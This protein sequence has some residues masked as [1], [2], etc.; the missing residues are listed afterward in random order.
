[1]GKLDAVSG[2][3]G[4][5]LRIAGGWVRDRLLGRESSDMDIAVTGGDG[6]RVARAAARMFGGD[7]HELGLDKT[8]S[9]S[10]RV[11]GTAIDGMD[12]EFVPMRTEGY[13]GASRVPT[14]LPTDSVDE[15][16][17]RRDFT[18]NA[19]Y[20]NTHTSQVEDPTGSGLSDLRAGVLRTPDDPDKSMDDD[21]L[22]GF[23]AARFVSQLGFRAD[24]ALVA[25][26]SRPS[27]H[28]RIESTVA[29]ERYAKELSKLATSDNPAA[30]AALLFDTGMYRAMLGLNA[31]A[32]WSPITM[33][34]R[35][36]YHTQNLRDHV[37]SV[38]EHAGKLATE[39]GLDR[40][41]RSALV[42]AAMFH[43]FGKMS[44]SAQQE[45]PDGTRSYIGHDK[46]GA[47]M[48][49]EFFRRAGLG[50]VGEMATEIVA[51]H[52]RP[53]GLDTSNPKAVGRFIRTHSPKGNERLW[54]L[55][56]IHAAADKSHNPQA[57]EAVELVRTHAESKPRLPILNGHDLMRMFP[58]RNPRSGFITAI[59]DAL[60]DAQS[61]GEVVDRESAQRWVLARERGQKGRAYTSIMRGPRR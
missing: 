24:P 34:Q 20:Y 37:V 49:G 36:R 16:A 6:V 44:P 10:L 55:T 18:V 8:G 3:S 59:Q 46:L 40:E 48:A 51:A 26:L 50:R 27:F 57:R 17:K 21:P 60:V 52:M 22:R 15:D 23:R 11:G 61:T 9:A 33:D 35:N 29:P 45:K 2:A 42:L 41:E 30:G 14:M 12:V 32:N 13:T 43:D 39:Y 28:A 7:V 54:F 4:T 31:T 56:M 1:M 5:T 25:A 47:E 38:V 58:N 19:L 53:H